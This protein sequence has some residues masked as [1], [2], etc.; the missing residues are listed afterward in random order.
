MEHSGVQK[1]RRI[2]NQ[3]IHDP[4][5]PKALQSLKLC[6]I[7]S[8]A[9]SHISAFKLLFGNKSTTDLRLH[10]SAGDTVESFYSF[11]PINKQFLQAQNKNLVKQLIK[12]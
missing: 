4:W 1:Q 7:A 8:T 6:R 11:Q 12:I 2:K 9:E 3:Q 5:Q 10:Y